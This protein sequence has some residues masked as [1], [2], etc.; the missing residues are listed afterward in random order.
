MPPTLVRYWASFL[1]SERHGARIAAYFTRSA[2][3]GWRQILVCEREPDDAVWAE[4]LRRLGVEMTFLPRAR[5]N[6]DAR[7]AARTL[8]LCRRERPDIFHCDNTHTSPLIGAWLAGVPVR[9]WTKH[10]ME[11][12]FETGS[13]P[14]FRDRLAISLRV[15]TRLATRTLPISEA[16]RQELVDKGIAP[17]RL[18]LLHLPVEAPSSAR[19]SHR[20]A[21]A[22]LGYA[23]A[24]LVILAIGRAAPVKGWD[25]LLRAFATVHAQNPSTRLLLVGGVDAP[26][27]RAVHAGMQQFIDAR[28]LDPFVRF[29]GRLPDIA[30]AL[31]AADLF[32]LPS[33]AE[34]YALALVEAL[35]AGLPC[36]ASSS[37]AGAPELIAHGRNGLIFPREDEAALSHMILDLAADPAR[38][39]EMAAAASRD[40]AVPTLAEHSD[41]LYRLYSSLLYATRSRRATA[42]ASPP[43]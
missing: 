19:P 39:R 10:A 13:Q 31:R 20:D 14:G 8:A 37:V 36:I 28:R 6:F 12:A 35:R 1:K 17:S 25:I 43:S 18:H 3:E 26:D 9:L 16:M 22:R 7:C 2:A 21:R 24:D 11:P 40:V 42:P 5:G 29:T 4:P 33:R 34:G 23:A 27:E 15:S 30:D 38:M 41:A 32:V